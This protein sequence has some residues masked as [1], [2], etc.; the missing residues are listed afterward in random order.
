MHL[1][2]PVFFFLGGGGGE[3]GAGSHR[4]LHIQSCTCLVECFVFVSRQC[5]IFSFNL[6]SRSPTIHIN[7][8][9]AVNVFGK[10]FSRL[11]P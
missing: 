7:N 10:K 2:C 9:Y 3:E 5:L 6:G 4:V 11:N 1:E 8:N